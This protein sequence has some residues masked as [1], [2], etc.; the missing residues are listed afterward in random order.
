[1]LLLLL[2]LLLLFMHLLSSPATPLL[3][4]MLALLVDIAT[5]TFSTTVNTASCDAAVCQRLRRAS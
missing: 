1:M 5:A 2:F 4:L 3:L